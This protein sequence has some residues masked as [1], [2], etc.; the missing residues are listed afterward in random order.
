MKR[1]R[2]LGIAVVLAMALTAF[3]GAGSASAMSSFRNLEGGTTEISGSITGEPK[4]H[5]LALG[6]E[7]YKCSNVAFSGGVIS[8]EGTSSLTVTPELANC[9]WQPPFVWNWKMNGCKFR[10]RSGFGTPGSGLSLGWVD[11]VNCAPAMSIS[12]TMPFC[13]VTIGN[14]NGIGTVQFTNVAGAPESIRMAASLSGIT[15]TRTGVCPASGGTVTNSNGSYYG[16]WLMKG[17]SKGVQKPIKVEPS[18]TVT[19]FATEE[20][21][22]PITGTA[23]G[24]PRTVFYIGG[25]GA[26]ECN[27][28]SLNGAVLMSP[29]AGTFTTTA[30]Y[31]GCEFLGWSGATINM[32]ACSYELDA[33]GDFRIVGASC[34]SNPITVTSGA[35]ENP[36]YKCVVTIG[37]QS[38][39]GLSYFGWG[40]GKTRTVEKRGEAKNLTATATGSACLATGTTSTG[41]Y[42]DHE[43]LKTTNMSG[44]QRGFWVE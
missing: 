27:G 2:T 30:T 31:S 12:S 11:I 38:L 43:S 6:I 13:E 34:A 5:T 4:W 18:E 23:A 26:V 15:Y 17:F 21:P 22:A 32:G 1:T 40:S 42:K 33:D 8:G 25:N 29:F 20:A 39:T 24:T 28:R 9:E 3:A 10:I 44:E 35:T 41:R 14:Q 37:P 36:N 19:S 16:E 7:Q